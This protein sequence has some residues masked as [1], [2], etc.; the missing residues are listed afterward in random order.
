[1]KKLLALLISALAF[2][3]QAKE[4]ITIFYA[5]GP[6]DSVANYD[7]TLIA[8]ANRIQD[9]YNFVFDTK[10]GAG[11]AIASNH[12]LNTPNSILS[13]STAFFVRPNFYPNESYNIPDFKELMTQCMAPMGITS[14][15]YKSWKEVPTD[16]PITIG[17]SGLGV[18]THLA[19]IQIQKKYPNLNIIPFKATSESLV[20]MVSG[21]TDL[22]VGFLSEAEQWQKDN[23]GRVVNVLGITGTKSINGYPTLVSEGFPAVFGQM[24]VGFHLLVPAKQDNAK[25][26]ELYTILSKAAKAKSVTD[27]Y[28]IDYCAPLDTPQKDLS[29]FFDFHTEHWKKLSSGVKLDK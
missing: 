24:N 8:E 19:A 16:Q 22:H 6:G 13:H 9:K 3:A 26:R 7:R 10:P 18:T 14:S 21:Q 12:V 29:K 11:G 20:S 5:W 15:K 23:K 2:T 1:M 25:T 27:S 4:T 17:I 28:A